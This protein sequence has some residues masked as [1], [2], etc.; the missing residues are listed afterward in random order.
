MIRRRTSISEPQIFKITRPRSVC[1][2]MLASLA[3]LQSMVAANAA[4]PTLEKIKSSG[5]I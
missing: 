2:A 3:V 4:S 5:K 1:L